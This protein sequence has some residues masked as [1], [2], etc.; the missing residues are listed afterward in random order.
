M[1]DEDLLPPR[2][3]SMATKPT[4][5][6]WTLVHFLAGCVAG[7]AEMSE[8]TWIGLMILWEVWE[9]S[10]KAPEGWSEPPRNIIMDILA[11][12]LGYKLRE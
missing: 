1:Q 6:Q 2:V 9:Q 10:P 8:E 12:Y 5:D 3:R 11:G 7:G 4:I